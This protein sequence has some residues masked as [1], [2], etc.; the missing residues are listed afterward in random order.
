EIKERLADLREVASVTAADIRRISHELRPALLDDMGLKAGLERYCGDVGA[1]AG[2]PIEAS[3]RLSDERLESEVE[4]V[5]YRVVQEAITNALKS[6]SPHRIDVSLDDLT[7][8]LRL[9]IA[10]DGSGFDP[11]AMKGK[12]L[13]LTGMRERAELIGGKLEIRSMPGRGTSIE[14]EVARA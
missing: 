13:G 1:R 9:V 14:L 3:V 8:D 12:G 4:T 6:A 10:D 11:E 7:G 2:I 5:L